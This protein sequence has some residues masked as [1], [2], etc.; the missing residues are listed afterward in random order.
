MVKSPPTLKRPL[1]IVRQNAS[2]SKT[3]HEQDVNHQQL[4]RI[5]E[6]GATDNP[7]DEILCLSS[8]IQ[9]SFDLDALRRLHGDITM[10]FEGTYPGF[11]R[12]ITRYHNLRHTCSVVLASLRLLHGL[13]CTDQSISSHVLELTILCAY[14]HDTGLLR[15]DEA[16]NDSCETFQSHNHEFRSVEVLTRYLTSLQS[17]TLQREEYEP[18][19]Q[20]TNL[21]LSPDK[22]NFPSTEAKLAGYVLGTADI[23]AQ[24]ADRCYLER[25]PFLFQEHREGGV[26]THGSAIELMQNTS[27]FY[28]DIIAKRLEHTFAGIPVAMQTHFRERWQIND[29]LYATNI[30]KNLT[31]LTSILARCEDR[32]DHLT[33]YLKR[34]PAP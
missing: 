6:S 4:T 33:T 3:N 8:L 21:S 31:Y 12:S 27:T 23:L 16:H 11:H 29:N 32:L 30:A 13:S 20:C 26:K 15:T 14:F 18:V 17:R 5:F 2:F 9:P 34:N 25:L 19:I 22:I 24:M 7:A 10:I 1:P 28:Q